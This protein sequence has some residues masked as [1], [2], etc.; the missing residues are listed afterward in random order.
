MNLK[1]RRVVGGKAEGEALVCYEDLSFSSIDP[2]TGIG[3]EKGH[4][5]EGQSIVG[6]IL[7][8]PTGTGSTGGSYVIYEMAKM[9][10]APAAILTAKADEITATGA[11]MGNIPMMHKFEKDPIKIIKT[12][13]RLKVDGDK[14][15]VEVVKS[16]G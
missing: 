7:V 14:G 2:K 1:G 15:I 8:I 13:D 9:K 10:S 12:G 16:K 5:L 6:K 3:R 4:P 11:I